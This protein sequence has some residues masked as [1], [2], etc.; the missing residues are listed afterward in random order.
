MQEKSDRLNELSLLNEELERNFEE[1]DRVF[2]K[3]NHTIKDLEHQI[4]TYL[5]SI[6]DKDKVNINSFEAFYVIK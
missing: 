2:N 5:S 1:K 6:Q 4:E 3:L